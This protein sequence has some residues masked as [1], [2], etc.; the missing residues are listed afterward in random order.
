M[1]NKT[2][3]ALVWG[4]I[5]PI[6]VWAQDPLELK[7]EEALKDPL[8]KKTEIEAPATV[9]NSDLDSQAQKGTFRSDEVQL[10]QVRKGPDPTAN[11]LAKI[12]PDKRNELK[13]HMSRASVYV[14]GIRLQEALDE[15]FK[16]EAIANEFDVKFFQ[17][18]N[19]KGAVYT[20]MRSFEEARVEFEKAIAI[21]G[22][23]FHPQFNLAE[24]DFV[25]ERFQGAEDGF[26]KLLERYGGLTPDGFRQILE[27]TERLMQFKVL[28]CMLKEGREEDAT[29]LIAKFNYLEDNPAYYYGNAAVEFSKENKEEAQSWMKSAERIYDPAIREI[30]MDSFVEVGWV[31][32]L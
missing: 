31:E 8:D 26:S 25:E 28:I 5:A 17:L 15:L 18:H 30:F 21:D 27:S 24:L 20:K 11:N 2:I 29:N 9:A 16:A 32:T 4:A 3:I 6:G 12:P 10:K 1:K 7:D 13:D 22:E 19:L 23:S 14:R